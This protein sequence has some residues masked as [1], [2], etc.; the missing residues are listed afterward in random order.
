MRIPDKPPRPGEEVCSE[1][2]SRRSITRLC[3]KLSPWTSGGG[4]EDRL[5]WRYLILGQACC[6]LGMMED[7]MLLLQNGKR[8]ASAASRRFSNGMRDDEFGS[9]IGVDA[10]QAAEF[11]LVNH[12][13]AN[14]KLLLRRRGAAEAALEAGLYTE[15]VRHFTMIIDN[16]KSTPPAFLEDCYLHRAIAYQ[17]SG[18]VVDAIADCNRT[19][20][21]NPRCTKALSVRASL[22]E[23]VES[24]TEC[25][26]DLQQ[27]KMIYEAALR[28][29][30]ASIDW[31]SSRQ[32]SGN[33]DL[34]DV[35]ISGSLDYINSKIIATR[36]RL[37]SKTCSLAARTVLDVPMHCTMEDV[38][39][40]YLLLSLKHSPEQASLFVENCAY[41]D[42]SRDLKTVKEEAKASALRLSH[43]IQRA[44]TKLLSAI[45]EEQAEEQGELHLYIAASRRQRTAHR[46]ASSEGHMKKSSRMVERSSSQTWRTGSEISIAQHDYESDDEMCRF[47]VCDYFEEDENSGGASNY[48][49]SIEPETKVSTASALKGGSHQC[50]YIAGPLTN[51]VNNNEQGASERVACF[52]VQKYARDS[53]EERIEEDAVADC[54]NAETLYG[55]R[56]EDKGA[57]TA[58]MKALASFKPSADVETDAEGDPLA[59]GELRGLVNSFHDELNRLMS[60]FHGGVCSDALANAIAEAFSRDNPNFLAHQR[61]LMNVSDSCP[62]NFPLSQP[63]SVT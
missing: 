17:A 18:R 5:G 46:R 9:D 50:K 23:M 33:Q 55:S 16:S 7:A 53:L 38:E 52:S 41:Q 26:L 42:R 61:W 13:L 60:S 34:S 63:L 11:D 14:I 10:M 25:L 12:M 54:S 8:T 45:S 48:S 37:S 59:N 29:H 43:L 39:K 21:L 3:Q 30:Q 22:H 62:W 36:S 1:S 20:A 47:S 58:V 2:R 57:I 28:R 27:L 19:L 24:F 31:V 44:Y 6:H 4:P 35:S 32:S 56:G 15:S 51:L 40:A 49:A